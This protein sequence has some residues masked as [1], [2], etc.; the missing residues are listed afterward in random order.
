MHDLNWVDWG[1][2]ALLAWGLV[3]GFGR[4]L[5]GI[6]AGLGAAVASWY[7]AARYAPALALWI[8]RRLGLVKATA[9][10]IEGRLHLGPALGAIPASAAVSGGVP[11]EASRQALTTLGGQLGLP[12]FLQSFLTRSLGETLAG[13]PGA[14]SMNLGQALPYLLALLLWTAIF[15]ALAAWVISRLIAF[16]ANRAGD[17]LSRAGLSL[18]NRLAGA[19]LG[20]VENG[21]FLAVLLGV[22]APVINLRGAVPALGASRLATLVVSSFSWLLNAL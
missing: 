19:L 6:V 21:L 5:V 13:V 15:F 16:V 14:G 22:V 8:D 18:P 4:G 12:P 7:L 10:A 3:S 11:P 2:I 17:L 1:I 9:R 20:V